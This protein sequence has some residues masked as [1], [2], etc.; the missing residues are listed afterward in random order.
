MT[1][2][3]TD[4]LRIADRV[5]AEQSNEISQTQTRQRTAVT[6]QSSTGTENINAIFKLDIRF[7]LAFVRCHF[8]G[9]SATAPMTIALDALAGV[10]YDATLFTIT[11]AGVARD[12][13]LRIPAEESTDPSPWT[14]QAGDAGRIQWTNP[15]PTNITW[16]LQVGLA[17]AS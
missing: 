1:Q 14:F 2:S 11:R 16:G 4:I 10:S 3:I 7:R 9:T 5:L 6:V 17:I 8:I 12:I 13:N 15:D